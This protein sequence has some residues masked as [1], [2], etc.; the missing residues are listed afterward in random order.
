MAELVGS[1]V[2]E[3]GVVDERGR[4]GEPV[5]NVMDAWS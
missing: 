5:E 4:A 2:V 3:S 1:E